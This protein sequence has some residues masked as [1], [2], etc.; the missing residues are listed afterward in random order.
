MHIITGLILAGLAGKYKGNPA[1]GGL[2]R[3]RTGPVRVT[4]ALEGRI[5]FLVPSLRGAEP[6][7]L[8]KTLELRSLP[9]VSHVEAS[10]VTGSVLLVYRPDEVDPPLLFAALVRLL[11]LE[12]ELGHP[13]PPMLLSEIRNMGQSLNHAVYD[14]TGGV[15][16]LWT[17]LILG[18]GIL[19]TRKLLQGGWTAFPTGF[20]LLWWALHGASRRNGGAS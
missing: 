1:L 11:G 5:R 7:D 12:E 2:P 19:G 16:D 6:G 17:V 10:A 13:P 9:G 8:E 18:L 4:H 20:T 15:A 3:F 14:R